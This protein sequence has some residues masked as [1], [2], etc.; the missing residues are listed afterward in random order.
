M[1][2]SG[3]TKKIV[4]KCLLSLP[5]HTDIL[6]SILLQFSPN[7]LFYTVLKHQIRPFPTLPP[8]SNLFPPFPWLHPRIVLPDLAV[9]SHFTAAAN[10]KTTRSPPRRG[11]GKNYKLS[12]NF[13]KPYSYFTYTPS[14]KSNLPSYL[15]QK[16]PPFFSTSPLLPNRPF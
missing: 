16:Y 10:S 11:D 6:H 12:D 15:Y 1:W 4:N 9:F 7:L 3:G 8:R 2:I 13:K 14:Q 5:K